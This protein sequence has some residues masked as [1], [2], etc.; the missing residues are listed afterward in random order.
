VAIGR[1]PTP[2]AGRGSL[3]LDEAGRG[4]VL[5]PLVVGGFLL[6]ESRLGELRELGVRDS[7]LLSPTRRASIARA[8]AELGTPS[9]ISIPPPRIDRAVARGGLNDLEAEAFGRLVRRARPHRSFVDACDPVEARFGR[10]V[11]R[12]A[13]VP[14]G[15]VIARHHADRD[16]LLVGAA[17][18]I[19]K[20]QR[21]AEVDAL[22]RTLPEEIGSGYPSDPT[23]RRYVTDLV[24]RGAP[25]PFWVRG[26]WKTVRNLKRAAATR[27]LDA[28]S[29]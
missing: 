13:G 12:R 27:T 17:S 21:D 19:A 11:A 2:P 9:T 15:R 4:S 7:K 18:I 28:Y 26:S 3:G 23:T 10:L 1:P 16:H 20:V 6:P 8:L 14:P 25:L 29:A 22:R 5:G 24:E